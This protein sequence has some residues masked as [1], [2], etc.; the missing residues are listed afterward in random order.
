MGECVGFRPY[1][2]G[3]LLGYADFRVTGGHVYHGCPVF[4]A[5]EGEVSVGLP[6]APL[7]RNGV[8]VTDETGKVMYATVIS[9]A[10]PEEYRRFTSMAV[11]ELRAFLNDTPSQKLSSLLGFDLLRSGNES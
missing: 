3:R 2:S 11:C 7:M 6:R 1:Q 5:D 8:P 10:D 4:Q 9:I